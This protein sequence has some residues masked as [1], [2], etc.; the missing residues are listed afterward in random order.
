M[1]PGIW[2]TGLRIQGGS[3]PDTGRMGT[4]YQLPVADFPPSDARFAPSNFH[5]PAFGSIL[6]ISVTVFGLLVTIWWQ[7]SAL[8]S[9]FGPILASIFALI[10][11]VVRK[12]AKARFKMGSGMASM[13]SSIKLWSLFVNV[14][15]SECWS[16]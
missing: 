14:R 16:A 8:S 3:A 2:H 7:I 11:E 15:V 1:D 4:G 6:L 12:R 13:F 9:V 10:F 5:F